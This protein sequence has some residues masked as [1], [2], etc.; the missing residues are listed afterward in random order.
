MI[1]ENCGMLTKP[2]TDGSCE[3]CGEKVAK[4]AAMSDTAQPALRELWTEFHNLIDARV[5]EVERIAYR[6]VLDKLIAAN[7][8][9]F[10]DSLLG[11]LLRATETRRV[12][13][14]KIISIYYETFVTK[15]QVKT[16]LLNHRSK[17]GDNND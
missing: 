6:Q 11:E 15:D 16:I 7:Q 10:I 12:I 5:P 9:S 2:Y 8:D 1:C 13:S 14:P 3:F 4:E 17:K